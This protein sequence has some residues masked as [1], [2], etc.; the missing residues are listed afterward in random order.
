[1]ALFSIQN[2][3]VKK[4]PP[5][6]VG[7]ERDIQKIFEENLNEILDITFLASEYSTSFGGRIDSLGIDNNGS[8]VIIEYKRNQN[9][10][11]INQGLS[12]LQWLL[13]HKADFEV[14]VQKAKVDI[15]IDWES[16][17][18]VCVAGTYNKFDLDTAFFL[19][20][21]I[22][23]FRFQIY[24]NDFLLVELETP[25]KVRISTS[26]VFDRGRKEKNNQRKP[27]PTLEDHLRRTS[28]KIMKKIF[29]I[30]NEKIVALD[31]SIIVEPKE[32]YIA[33]KL[34]TNFVDIVIQKDSFKIFLNVP[35]GE[36]NDPYG[37]ARDL[38]KPNKVGHWGNGDYEASLG[39]EEEI[40]QIFD[41][42]KQ[43]YVYNK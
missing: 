10:N 2:D 22:E 30:I 4:I 24:Q 29:E 18:V 40:D 43:S 42:I 15:D 13:D 35:S 32:Q 21:N 25:Q 3:N 27:P 23:L 28:Q 26:K 1:M 31:E 6:K 16:P 37:I 36:L 8:P 19:P 11:V 5:I 14:L 7:K 41:L 12:Y 38:T 34:T 33:Y 17:R 9:G 20:I 39:K